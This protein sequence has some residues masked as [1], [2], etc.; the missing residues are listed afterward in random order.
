MSREARQ[1]FVDYSHLLEYRDE[2]SISVENHLKEMTLTKNNIFQSISV[3][4]NTKT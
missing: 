1:F 4:K 2:S 3:N